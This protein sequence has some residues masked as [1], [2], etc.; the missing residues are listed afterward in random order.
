LQHLITL[1]LYFFFL[2]SIAIQPVANL[3]IY[4]RIV[5]EAFPGVIDTVAW[6]KSNVAQNASYSLSVSLVNMWTIRP[7]NV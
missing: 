2:L 7:C 4:R 5:S 3:L 1:F 6:P